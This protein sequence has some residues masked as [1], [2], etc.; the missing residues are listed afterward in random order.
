MST[1]HM[2]TSQYITCDAGC[3]KNDIQILWKIF[4]TS[5]ILLTI[6]YIS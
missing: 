1:Y 4:T 5:Y 3:D 6:N 2:Q